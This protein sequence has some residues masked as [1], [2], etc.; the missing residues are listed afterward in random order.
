MRMCRV[1]FLKRGDREIPR[2]CS[3]VLEVRRVQFLQQSND[4]YEKR[5]KIEENTAIRKQ[6]ERCWEKNKRPAQ[7]KQKRKEAE[8]RSAK[9]PGQSRLIL[10]L[11]AK[12]NR[13]P[14]GVPTGE[15][16]FRTRR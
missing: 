13:E 4:S 14:S 2:S 6:E 12:P 3:I 7:R 9:I 11:A 8:L 16:T 10:C 15:R 1:F 5:H